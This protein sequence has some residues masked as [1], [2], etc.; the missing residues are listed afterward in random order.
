M[1]ILVVRKV[2]RL[3]RRSLRNTIEAI[4]HDC[5]LSLGKNPSGG[6]HPRM[7]FRGF[8]FFRNKAHVERERPL[9]SFKPR[10]ERLAKAPGPHLGCGFWHRYS[11]SLPLLRCGISDPLLSVISPARA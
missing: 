5:Q 11:L 1:K 8:N 6:N 9:P 7:G 2:L 10:V 4:D 3:V